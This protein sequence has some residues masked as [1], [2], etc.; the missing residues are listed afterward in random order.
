MSR[1]LKQF[2]YL[3]WSKISAIEKGDWYFKRIYIDGEKMDNTYMRL[4]KKF[5]TALEKGKSSDKVMQAMVDITPNCKEREKEVWAE[6]KGIKLRGF[7]DGW[8]EE[9]G[10]ITEYKTGKE[11]AW[12]LKKVSESGQLQ[13]YSFMFWLNTGKIPDCRLYWYKTDCDGQGNLFLTGEREPFNWKFDTADML[14]M[15]SRVV[16]DYKKI[17]KLIKQL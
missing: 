7:L 3:S 10:L 15:A 1:A 16:R 11:G 9:K 13:F 14:K 5:A 8:D 2:D 6:Y 12:N 4:G 17:I